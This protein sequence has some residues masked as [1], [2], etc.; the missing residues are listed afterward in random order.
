[1][2]VSRRLS[3]TRLATASLAAAML[4][5][6]TACADTVH[7][8]YDALGRLVQV[9]Y[10]DGAI[11]QYSY[12]AAGNRTQVTQTTPGPSSPPPPPPPAA[13]PYVVV[14]LLGYSLIPT[15]P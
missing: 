7:Y 8:T 4:G 14:P 9:Q 12:D 13:Q 1:M 15:G 5:A 10:G 2:I 3:F 6:P 11:V